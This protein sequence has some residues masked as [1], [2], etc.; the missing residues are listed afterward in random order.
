M[1]EFNNSNRGGGNDRGGNDRRG[2]GNDRGG[3]REQAPRAGDT[4]LKEK[5]VA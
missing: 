3:N 2:G 4:D 1:A 5:V